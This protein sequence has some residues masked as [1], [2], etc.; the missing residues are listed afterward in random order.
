MNNASNIDAVSSSDAVAIH[1]L[2]ADLQQC[3]R[4]LNF[5]GI[6]ALWDQSRAPIYLAE[7]AEQ[8]HTTWA[9]LEA[10]WQATT[11]S[12]ERLQMRIEALQLI[13]LS[14][15]L[16]SAVYKMH[17]NGVVR[18]MPRPVGGDN[19]V[20]AT[21]RRTAAGWRFVQYVEAPLAPIVYMRKLYELA[22]DP[23]FS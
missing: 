14:P 12:I 15:E 10:Y 5:A 9:E 4:N 18:G 3:W 21:L 8:V 1:A 22:A 19:R 11:Q 16:I 17:W 7:E 23:G 2:L 13:A 20:V 6:R